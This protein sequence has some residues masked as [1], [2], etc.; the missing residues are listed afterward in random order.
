MAVDQGKVGEK[1]QSEKD[2]AGREMEACYELGKPVI[3][4]NDE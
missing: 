4:E 3:P 2:P 1:Y